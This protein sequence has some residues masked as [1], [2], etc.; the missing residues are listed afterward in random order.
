VRNNKTPL[1]HVP[2]PNIWNSSKFLLGIDASSHRPRPLQDI[3]ETEPIA[4][5][6]TSWKSEIIVDAIPNRATD[7]KIDSTKESPASHHWPGEKMLHTR[8]TEMLGISHP[9][10]SAPMTMHCGGKL[11]AAVSQA[12]GLGSF[13]GINPEGPD[14]VLQQIRHIRSQTDQP[15]GVGFITQMI[16]DLPDNFQA[17][18]DER[19][20]VIA[21]SFVDPKPWLAQAKD[22]SALVMCQVQSLQ[23]AEEAVSAGADVLVAQGNEAGGHTGGMNSLPLLVHLLNRYPQ[24]PVLA[25]GGIS[26]GRGLAAVLAAGAEG[27]WVGTAFLTTPGARHFQRADPIE[28]WPGHCVHTAVRPTGRRSLAPRHRGKG[29]PQPVRPGMGRSRRGHHKKS[30]R[31]G[32]RRGPSLGTTRPRRSIG[33]HGAVRG[34]R[35]LYQTGGPSL[36]GHLRPG[37]KHSPDALP[38]P[39][40]LGYAYISSEPNEGR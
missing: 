7:R 34:R 4:T 26:D 6:L 18:L 10:M 33:V 20:P 21:F 24:L 28:R 3:E 36:A 32:R 27:A 12:G 40:A 37:G 17:V 16:A 25:S 1:L 15:F 8:L 13:G 14:W 19:V 38:R 30:R 35:Q 2:S 11:A 5:D 31:T 29:L 23:G 9:V 39:P 22:S